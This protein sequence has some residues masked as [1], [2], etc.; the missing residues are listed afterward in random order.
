MKKKKNGIFLRKFP[1]KIIHFWI[2]QFYFGRKQKYLWKHCYTVK[3]PLK[4]RAIEALQQ[5]KPSVRNCVRIYFKWTSYAIQTS[6]L[7]LWFHIFSLTLFYFTIATI[8]L[9]VFSHC[10]LDQQ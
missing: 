9:I 8:C 2:Q 3:K 4:N 10:W 6:T 1:K 7:L 5:N